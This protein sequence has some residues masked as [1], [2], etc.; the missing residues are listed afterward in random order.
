LEARVSSIR[1]VFGLFIVVGMPPAIV[2]WFLVHPFIGFWRRVGVKGTLWTVAVLMVGLMVGLWFVRAPLLGRDLGTDWVRFGVGIALMVASGIMAVK[3]RRHLTLR[4]LAGVP[5]LRPDEP[6]ALLTQGP[7]A[8][9]RHPR[10]VEVVIG[11]FGYALLANYV[12]VYLVSLLCLPA[13]HALV[14]LEER[15]L[16][17]RFGAEYAAYSARVPRYVPSIHTST[18]SSTGR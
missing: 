8:V 7:Y 6:H 18:T 15:E 3:R 4:I 5:E 11:V 10:Y 16:A 13:L 1:Y 2:W 14:L 17:D 12:G 9:I